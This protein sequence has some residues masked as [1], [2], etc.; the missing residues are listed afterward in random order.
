[1]KILLRNDTSN[2]HSPS[3]LLITPQ[4][5][6]LG[7]VA[8]EWPYRPGHVAP[9]K[10]NAPTRATNNGWW[11]CGCAFVCIARVA[12]YT[13][14]KNVYSYVFHLIIMFF[15]HG[16]MHIDM[17]FYFLKF[18]MSHFLVAFPCCPPSLWQL[19]PPLCYP[20]LCLLEAPHYFPIYF[21]IVFP[22]CSLLF[23]YFFPYYFPIFFPI[24]FPI[25]SLFFPYLFP[26]LSLFFPLLLPYFFPYFFPYYFPMFSLFVPLLFPYFFPYYFP[27][28]SLFSVLLPY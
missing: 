23:P 2:T 5:V 25:I 4:W 9:S 6:S 28:F 3:F 15:K 17:N 13:P 14:L 16:W 21:P 11:C 10:Q 18:S 7:K 27:F 1:M 24:F 20:A 12:I 26:I 19:C 22:I 8:E